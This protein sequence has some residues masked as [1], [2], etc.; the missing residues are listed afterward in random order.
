MSLCQSNHRASQPYA[1][2]VQYTGLLKTGFEA[3]PLVPGV[4]PLLATG[5]YV[6]K[7]LTALLLLFVLPGLVFAQT[8]AQPQP[9]AFDVTAPARSLLQ[10]RQP[11]RIIDVHLHAALSKVRD[12]RSR[13][14]EIDPASVDAELQEL[15]RLLNEHHVTVGVLSSQSLAV[16]ERWRAAVP[17]LFLVG[18]HVRAGESGPE[19]ETLRAIY[20]EGRLG[21]IGEIATP[22]TDP[23]FDRYAAL[24]EELDVPLGVHSTGFGGSTREN[25]PRLYEPVLARHPKLRLYLMHAGYPWLDETV[26]LLQRHKTTFADLSM[27]NYNIPREDF[28]AYLR[29]LVKAGFANRLMYGSDTGGGPQTADHME[30]GIDAIQSADFLTP[31]QKRAIFYDNAFRFF[32]LSKSARALSEAKGNKAEQEIS[33]VNRDFDEAERQRDFAAIERTL[34]DDFIWTTFGGTVFDRAETSEHLKSGDSGYEL[35]E[36]DDVRI[37]MYGDTAVVTARLVRRGR[38]SKRDLSGEFRYTRVYVK[39]AGRWRM[40]AYQMTRIG[41]Q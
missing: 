10:P 35:Y 32:R 16:A 30:G 15:L 39:Q 9:K 25:H 21:V 19:V 3:R 40:V 34:A 23:A 36:S 38:D 37:R 22:P 33:R 20:R 4:G 11:K 2:D 41:Q 17:G 5:T 14:E 24:A 31:D 13:G 1:A 18:P 12:A 27:I 26:S 28:H 8:K 7:T 29:S 6:V